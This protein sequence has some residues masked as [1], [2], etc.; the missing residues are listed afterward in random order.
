MGGYSV[1]CPD[2]DRWFLSERGIR[3]HL[4]AKH[5]AR[6]PLPSTSIQLWCQEIRQPLKASLPFRTLKDFCAEGEDQ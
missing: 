3:D 1:R 6:C 5:P 2:C 4:K